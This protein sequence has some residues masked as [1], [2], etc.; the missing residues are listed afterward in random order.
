VEI[1]QRHSHGY[2]PVQQGSHLEPLDVSR[3]NVSAGWAA[4]ELISTA[5]DLN[6]FF[7]ALIDGKLLSDEQFAGMTTLV[8]GRDYGLGIR[9]MQLSC[10][11]TAYGHDGDAPGYST[12]SFVTADGKRSATVSINPWGP[13]K[14][15]ATVK[16]LIDRALCP[17]PSD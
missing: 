12:W 10:G 6:S 8:P 4:G 5:A 9:R 2:L 7:A 3:F 14:P 16:R 13:T 17:V 15:T 11:I 1:A